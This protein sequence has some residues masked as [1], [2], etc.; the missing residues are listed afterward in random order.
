MTGS[1]MKVGDLVEMSA[2]GL[3][4]QCR[5]RER[6]KKDVGVVTRITEYVQEQHF[7]VKWLKGA[8]MWRAKPYGAFYT[9]KELKLAKV[10]KKS[11]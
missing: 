6:N 5:W 10:K 11:E 8:P 2:Y 1:G 3:K 4:L 9:R 7:Q